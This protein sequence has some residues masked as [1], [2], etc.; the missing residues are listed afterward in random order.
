M[1]SVDS[2]A[3]GLKR[4][5]TKLETDSSPQAKI[6]L[7]NCLYFKLRTKRPRVKEK[8]L[9]RKHDLRTYLQTSDFEV[10]NGNLG[11]WNF[12]LQVYD[13]HHDRRFAVCVTQI[14]IFH[15]HV[16]TNGKSDRQAPAVRVHV[17]P[18]P[19]RRLEHRVC[20]LPA[21]RNEHGGRV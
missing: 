4:R 21:A 20:D 5:S 3:S 10:G 2:E 7:Q 16:S 6:A 19:T 8:H 9:G 12:E 17:K 1:I 14:F 11:T 13:Q 15:F 18:V